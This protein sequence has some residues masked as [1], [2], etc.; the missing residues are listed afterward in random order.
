MRTVKILTIL[1]L[2]LILSIFELKNANCW[3]EQSVYLHIQT[4]FGYLE[5]RDLDILPVLE[6]I[7]LFI[8]KVLYRF[9]EATVHIYLRMCYY[10]RL[11]LS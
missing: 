9:T 1:V 3:H 7:Y 8:R 10:M 11:V 6:W 2:N 5:S 4:G